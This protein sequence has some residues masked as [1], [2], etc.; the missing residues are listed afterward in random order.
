MNWGENPTSPATV[1]GRPSPIDCFKYILQ[2]STRMRKHLNESVPTVSAHGR[3]EE[4][5]A[6][7][8]LVRHSEPTIFPDSLFKKRICS[9]RNPDV[10]GRFLSRLLNHG[11]ASELAMK[12][13][14]LRVSAQACAAVSANTTKRYTISTLGSPLPTSR[15]YHFTETLIKLSIPRSV[16][17]SLLLTVST[18]A[19]T[20]AVSCGRGGN[21]AAS[22]GKDLELRY[23]RNITITEYDSLTLV[24]L[25][26]PWDTTRNL[27]K[28]AL[29]DKTLKGKVSIPQGAVE[30]GVPL[31]N[32][33]VY[34]AVHSSL[35]EELGAAAAVSGV[36]DAEYVYSP[37]MLAAL[38]SGKVI[39]CGSNFQPNV[40][41][42][43]GLKP[44][45]ILLSPYENSGD[46]G[47]VSQ[48]GIPIVETADYME[49][50]PLARA[51]WMRFYGRLYGKVA[52]AD[53]IFNSTER[54][55]LEIKNRT[56]SSSRRPKVLFDRIYSGVWSVA[57]SGSVTGAFIEDAGGANPFSA[58]SDAGNVRL[59]PEK[60]LVTGG[61]A[62][63]W[64]VRYAESDRL[65]LA[66]MA[67]DNVLYTKFKAY[68]DG[69]VYGSDTR[70]SRVFEDA[71]FH[72]QKVLAN[73]VSILHPEI[74]LPEAVNRYYEKLPAK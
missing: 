69:N 46:H 70:T 57:T 9:R 29:V 17:L 72:P 15:L 41:K 10:W 43:I 24:T 35:I 74:E 37:Q 71:S 2:F 53:S 50:T 54:S 36:C 12:E 23:A 14:L 11:S 64:F 19:L 59:S 1:I 55:Y 28:Y 7:F 4:A 16:F 25:R 68:R 52:E 40:E 5:R 73:M 21:T 34:S 66:D 39:D 47:K 22:G 31:S 62:D 61:D 58:Y 27:A 63:I 42:M 26:D 44:D 6:K 60:V 45:A 8:R 20:L 65:T 33:I 30:I 18:M 51:E 32:S 56:A 38:K 49:R 13:E 67:K 48:F 3:K